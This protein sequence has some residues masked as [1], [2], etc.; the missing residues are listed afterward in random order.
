[1]SSDLPFIVASATLNNTRFSYSARLIGFEG[2]EAHKLLQQAMPGSNFGLDTYVG[3]ETFKKSLIEGLEQK[4][5]KI[6]PVQI[7]PM[8]VIGNL[9]ADTLAIARL[10]G[11]RSIVQRLDLD[12][13]LKQSSV[14]TKVAYSIIKSVY[15]Q[16]ANITKTNKRPSR[17]HSEKV[18]KII[19]PLGIAI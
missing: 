17:S 11:L 13:A 19:L 7:D 2:V 10:H 8:F 16:H 3:Y 4:T 1:V 15:L 5:L 14:Q 6:S 12:D 9:E 18:A